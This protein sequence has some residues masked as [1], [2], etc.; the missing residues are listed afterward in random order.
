MVTSPI[1]VILYHIYCIIE[2][3]YI[4]LLKVLASVNIFRFNIT[5]YNGLYF[6]VMSSAM[7][8]LI[9]EVTT[10]LMTNPLTLYPV[11]LPMLI[12]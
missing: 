7:R 3:M 1:S 6:G 9:G 4:V 5:A 8:L 11:F 2:C 12:S 10:P